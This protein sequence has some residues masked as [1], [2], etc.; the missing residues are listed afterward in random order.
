MRGIDKKNN[1][2]TFLIN[3]KKIKKSFPKDFFITRYKD[4]Y[5]NEMKEFIDCLI[6]NNK[7]SVGIEDAVNSIRIAI[8]AKL[9]YK[10]NKKVE[11]KTLY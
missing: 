9:S 6:N 11:L 3:D 10:K 1:T 4:A 2:N 8:A 5:I 7:P